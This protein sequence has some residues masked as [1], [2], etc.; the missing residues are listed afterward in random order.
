MKMIHINLK[1]FATLTRY[2][3]D[4][5]DHFEVGSG[6]DLQ[7]LVARLGI[8]LEETKLIFVNGIRREIDYRLT[9]GDRV[10]IFPPVGGG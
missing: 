1:L 10:G 4:S 3:P 7:Q 6:T 5:P 2:I 8:P 9:D